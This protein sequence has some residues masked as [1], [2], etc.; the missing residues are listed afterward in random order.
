M[1]KAICKCRT[2]AQDDNHER[3]YAIPGGHAF[4]D[5]RSQWLCPDPRKVDVSYEGGRVS[6]DLQIISPTQDS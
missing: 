6:H 3:L 5:L 1:D 2:K 4:P